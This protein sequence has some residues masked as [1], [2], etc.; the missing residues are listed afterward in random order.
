MF[1]IYVLISY[2]ESSVRC[3]VLMCEKC[4]WKKNF[5]IVFSEKIIKQKIDFKWSFIFSINLDYI[6][7]LSIQLP[8][9]LVQNCL[10]H[11]FI[12]YL[13]LFLSNVCT[14]IQYIQSYKLNHSKHNNIDSRQGL[15]LRPLEKS[16]V[17]FK[18][19]FK[20]TESQY[21]YQQFIS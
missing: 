14:Y 12:P 1:F 19:I 13:S 4:I 17:S 16:S 11:F 2:L 10:V 7:I 3:V 20:G 6:R 18:M 5:G 9:F 8:S 21:L 15:S